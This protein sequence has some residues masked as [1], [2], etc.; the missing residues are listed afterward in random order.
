M[1]F[2]ILIVGSGPS[3]VHA[4][5]E[6]VRCG[7]RVGMIDVGHEDEQFE[8]ITPDA[9][10][11]RLRETDEDQHRY[12][13]DDNAVQADPRQETAGSHLTPARRFVVRD[14]ERLLP[15]WS[16]TFE[17]FQSLAMGGLA[18]SWGAGCARFTSAEL[19]RAGMPGDEMAPW[20]EAVAREIG[21]SAPRSDDVSEA[22]G[23]FETKL[24]PLELDSNAECLYR[25]YRRHRRQLNEAGFRLGQPPV[26]ILSQPMGSRSPNPYHDMDYWSDAGASVWRPRL[27]L[28]TLR[29]EPAFSYIRPRLA[30]RYEERDD[31]TVEVLCRNPE[32]GSHESFGARRLLLAAGAINSARLALRSAGRYDVSTTLLCNPYSYIP[33]LN[34]PMLGRPARDRRHSMIQLSGVY[35]PGPERG[36]TVIVQFFSYRSLMLSTLAR[37]MPLPPGLA[38]IFARAIVSCLTIATVNHADA[39]P[40]GRWMVLRGRSAEDDYLQI[41]SEQGEQE[42]IRRKREREVLRLLFRLRLVPM[43]VMRLRDGASIHY[44]GTLPSGAPPDAPGTQAD[45]RVRGTQHV[46][47]VDSSGWNFLP[48]KGLTFTLMANA[49][50]LGAQIASRLAGSGS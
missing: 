1:N 4:A 15:V 45:G 3:G 36:D 37:D 7:A 39:P 49:R 23:A 25:S 46:F 14:T 44:A 2:D 30:Q 40:A 5:A 50:R 27:L 29:E 8:R 26:A 18:A 21:I 20:Y 32:T 28:R 47:A 42:K 10:W 41:E 34:R 11:S 35:E 43:R 6:A 19:E 33:S 12:F 24:P 16:D 17:A 48:A 38:M 9:P 31:G 22:I 13:L